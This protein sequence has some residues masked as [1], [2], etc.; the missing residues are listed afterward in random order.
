MENT[1]N[2]GYEYKIIYDYCSEDGYTDEHNLSEYFN[3]TWTE[4]QDYIK[5]MKRN[6][7]YNIDAIAIDYC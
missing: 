7:C 4:L 1:C 3:G 2:I 6:G 5:Q